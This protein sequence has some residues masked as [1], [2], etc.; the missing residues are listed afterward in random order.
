MDD[1]LERGPSGDHG[2]CRSTVISAGNGRRAHAL[3]AT[4]MQ[5]P[6]PGHARIRDEER[7]VA[8]I[9]GC[10][11][12]TGRRVSGDVHAREVA[13]A[14]V[15]VL[16][17]AEVRKDGQRLGPVGWRVV[18]EVSI[19]PSRATTTPTWNRTRLAADVRPRSNA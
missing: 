1:R 2:I 11:R 3:R 8:E 16:A 4:G 10:E 15:Y 6:T 12:G 5:M 14:V 17:E 7:R 19:G 18:A 13:A 9:I